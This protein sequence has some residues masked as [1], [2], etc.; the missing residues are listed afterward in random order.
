VTEDLFIV[1]RDPEAEICVQDRTDVKDVL[2][3]EFC[4]LVDAILYQAQFEEFVYRIRGVLLDQLYAVLHLGQFDTDQLALGF[5]RSY[6]GFL[7]DI[8]IQPVFEGIEVPD[9]L[10]CNV[11]EEPFVRAVQDDAAEDLHAH[12]QRQLVEQV[13][14]VDICWKF[15]ESHE[16]E[17]GG[18]FCVSVVIDAEIDIRSPGLLAADR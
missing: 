13:N 8:V 9:G 16:T 7:P 4:P 11:V 6:H 5:F 10:H 14:V 2:D 15:G 3:G 18:F 17:P 1:S 12:E